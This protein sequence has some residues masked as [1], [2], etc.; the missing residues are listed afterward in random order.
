MSL[1]FHLHRSLIALPLL[2]LALA[3]AASHEPPA[4]GEHLQR[5]LSAGLNEDCRNASPGLL[6]L[7]QV[8]GHL[9]LASRRIDCAG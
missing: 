9:G 5:G 6:G 4:V 3:V 1:R 2:A 7:T 8:P